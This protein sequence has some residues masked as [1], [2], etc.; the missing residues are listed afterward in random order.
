MRIPKWLLL[1]S[2]F[3]FVVSGTVRYHAWIASRSDYI[4]NLS[5]M[6]GHL[7]IG[8]ELIEQKTPI[9]AAI[10]FGHPVKEHWQSVKRFIGEKKVRLKLSSENKDEILGEIEIICRQDVNWNRKV[11]FKDA[12]DCLEDLAKSRPN[13]LAFDQLYD[14]I[15]QRLRK[16]L[17][18]R[19]PSKVVLEGV[20]RV[21]KMASEEYQ[22]SITEDDRQEGDNKN[23]VI[24]S[25]EYQDARGF[26]VYVSDLFE[27]QL[28]DYNFTDLIQKISLQYSL[29]QSQSVDGFNDVNDFLTSTLESIKGKL[30]LSN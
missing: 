17:R 11:K 15:D 2:V 12:F 22:A 25:I 30:E 27:D 13:S 21:L 4:E 20:D 5:L 24:N 10:H 1:F 3:F 9:P 16:L 19:L 6:G 26:I 18:V 29:N 28:R 23:I 7:T 8:K 14:A